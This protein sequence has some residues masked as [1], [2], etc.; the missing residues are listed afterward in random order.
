M[1]SNIHKR[2]VSYSHEK[3]KDF[4]SPL[5]KNLELTLTFKENFLNSFLLFDFQSRIKIF[6]VA[7]AAK[8]D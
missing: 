5:K 1:I 4:K 7:H 6:M 2:E 8:S 3:L